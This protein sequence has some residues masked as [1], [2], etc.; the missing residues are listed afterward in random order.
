MY[1][2]K[3]EGGGG[4]VATIPPPSWERGLRASLAINDSYIIRVLIKE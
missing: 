1:K 2:G 4:G 3:S